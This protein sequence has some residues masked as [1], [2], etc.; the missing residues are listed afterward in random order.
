MADYAE[1]LSHSQ[2]DDPGLI[3][4][5]PAR[6]PNAEPQRQTYLVFNST[7][8]FLSLTEDEGLSEKIS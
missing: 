1:G 4:A 3:S 8:K 6:P 5:V 7:V 2:P